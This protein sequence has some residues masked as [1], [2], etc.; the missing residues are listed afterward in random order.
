MKGDLEITDRADLDFAE[1][2]VLKGRPLLEAF[3]AE[4]FVVP[5][6]HFELGDLPVPVVV[7]DSSAR[8]ELGRLI[9]G[10]IIG[11]I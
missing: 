9:P 5:S 8:P 4:R 1:L 10:N 7:D 2:R 11:F 3:A 6:E